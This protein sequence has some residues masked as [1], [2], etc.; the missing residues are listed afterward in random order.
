M[1]PEDFVENTD[2]PLVQY[3][4]NRMAVRPCC[5]HVLNE[6]E[7]TNLRGRHVSRKV[8]LKTVAITSYDRSINESYGPGCCI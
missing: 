3:V 4:M 6:E 5:F 2:L 1:T 7:K 8:T